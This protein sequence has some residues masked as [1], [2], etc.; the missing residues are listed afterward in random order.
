MDRE[1]FKIPRN[2]KIIAGYGCLSIGSDGSASGRRA[3][4]IS[5]RWFDVSNTYAKAESWLVGSY[6]FYHIFN[7]EKVEVVFVD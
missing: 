1:Y 6:L 5:L 2:D 7:V 3:A 4:G